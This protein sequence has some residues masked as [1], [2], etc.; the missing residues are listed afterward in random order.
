MFASICTKFKN[1][2]GESMVMEVTRRPAWVVSATPASSVRRSYIS[3]P[4]FKMLQRLYLIRY[5]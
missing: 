5:I 2:Q 4:L 3:T 1:R